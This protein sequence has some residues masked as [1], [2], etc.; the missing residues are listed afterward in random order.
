MAQSEGGHLLLFSLG[1]SD[2]ELSEC[3]YRADSRG[4]VHRFATLAVPAM[5]GTDQGVRQ[6]TNFRLVVAAR[7]MPGLREGHFS[8]VSVG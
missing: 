2:W 5:P 8:D 3:V 4:R 7:K 6:R 1:H